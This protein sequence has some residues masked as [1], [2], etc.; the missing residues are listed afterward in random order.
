MP[1]SIHI[2][3][4]CFQTVKVGLG[5]SCL[6]PVHLLFLSLCPCADTSRFL[7]SPLIDLRVLAY[8]GPEHTYPF[9]DAA[10]RF[11]PPPHLYVLL[12][13]GIQPAELPLGSRPMSSLVANF[14]ELICSFTLTPRD[15]ANAKLEVKMPS[16]STVTPP[17]RLRPTPT[18]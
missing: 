6:L 9:L 14:F 5:W 10:L 2:G 16:W 1:R 8:L 3:W 13:E 18:S 17:W 11:Q 7:T 4:S 15:P 12:I